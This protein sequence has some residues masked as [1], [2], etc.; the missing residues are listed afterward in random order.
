M[1]CPVGLFHLSFLLPKGIT[2]RPAVDGHFASPGCS[3][4]ISHPL[5]KIL[6]PS[7]EAL[8]AAATAFLRS[9]VRA[10]GALSITA[11]LS[12]PAPA[13][14]SDGWTIIVG[15][16]IAFSPTGLGAWLPALSRETGAN[17]RPAA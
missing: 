1:R 17:S 8:F 7:R 10:P 4:R 13:G 2:F 16:D 3:F 12:S 15:A 6:G 11:L 14:G 9:L 5:V